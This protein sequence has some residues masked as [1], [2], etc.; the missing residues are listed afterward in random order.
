M[1][2]TEYVADI[3]KRLQSLGNKVE[4]F[5]K[6]TVTK[7][8]TTEKLEHCYDKLLTHLKKEK[9]LTDEDVKKIKEDPNYDKNIIQTARLM[10]MTT[11]DLTV[12]EKMCYKV[13]N[14]CEKIGLSNLSKHLMHKITPEKLAKIDDTEKV[15]AE[16]LKIKEILLEPIVKPIAVKPIPKAS[17][18]KAR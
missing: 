10:E 13:A 17:L 14:F 11:P 6:E 2:P 3:N 5:I 9:Y 16:S 8:I 1:N 12:V 15:V 4:D 18:G 7:D